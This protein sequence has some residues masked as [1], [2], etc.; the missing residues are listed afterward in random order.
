M[1]IKKCDRTYWILV[2]GYIVYVGKEKKLETTNKKYALEKIV[3][4]INKYKSKRISI[5][6]HNVDKNKLE[7][8]T[9]NTSYGTYST[10]AKEYKI[11]KVKKNG[12]KKM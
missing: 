8:V 6:K 2:K 1:E 5:I 11:K 10:Y 7:V 9:G 3:E 12:N 4:Y